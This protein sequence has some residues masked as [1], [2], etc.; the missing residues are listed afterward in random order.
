MFLSLQVPSLLTRSLRC[1]RKATKR[2][3]DLI[4]YMLLVWL[5]LICVNELISFVQ[6]KEWASAVDNAQKAIKCEEEGEGDEEES[7]GE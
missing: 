4:M 2:H 5:F 7:E 1:S 3:L 6:I